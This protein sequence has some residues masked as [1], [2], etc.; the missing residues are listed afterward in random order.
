MTVLETEE[1]LALVLSHELAHAVH[2]HSQAFARLLA[3]LAGVQ[4]VVL[5]VLDP[6]GLTSLLAEMGLPIAAKVRSEIALPA[7]G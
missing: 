1:Q 3:A 5:A 6:L 4:L 7:E 2:G